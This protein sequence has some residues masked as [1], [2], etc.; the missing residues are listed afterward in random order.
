MIVDLSYLPGVRERAVRLLTEVS[1]EKKASHVAAREI[2]IT[3][4]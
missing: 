3:I 1:S 2:Q 4:R